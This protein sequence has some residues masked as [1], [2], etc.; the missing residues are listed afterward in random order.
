MLKC[1]I[2]AGCDLAELSLSYP[3]LT[4]PN[5]HRE[6]DRSWVEFPLILNDDDNFLSAIGD[7]D[8]AEEVEHD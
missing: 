3:P 5:Q 7:P 2:S 4:Y 8:K 1:R 6:I